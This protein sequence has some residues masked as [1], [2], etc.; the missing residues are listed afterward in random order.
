MADR[1]CPYCGELVPSNSLTCPKCYKRI[2]KEPEPAPRREE[3]RETGGKRDYS[4]KIAVFLCL[5]PG[6]FGLLGLGLVYRNPRQKRGYI[7]LVIGLLVFV[8]AAF[9]TMGG[10]TIFL[11]VPFWIV[12][13]LMYLGCL[14]LIGLDNFSVRVF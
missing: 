7:A 5:I 2:P 6:L 9:L 10:F 1:R 3:R 4:R 11:A 8:A 14:A 12:Y 13:V